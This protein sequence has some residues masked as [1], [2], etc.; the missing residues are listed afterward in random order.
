MPAI[1]R[2]NEGDAGRA[3]RIFLDDTDAA[4]EE[5]GMSPDAS[6]YD[7]PPD[8]RR[9]PAGVAW[10]SVIALVFVAVAAISFAVDQNVTLSSLPAPPPA[11]SAGR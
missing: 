1:P 3:R 7:M 2:P 6:L 8:K 10:A 11:P 4:S 9:D 5:T